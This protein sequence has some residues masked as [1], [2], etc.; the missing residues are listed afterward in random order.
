MAKQGQSLSEPYAV[1]FR[2]Y[3]HSLKDCAA[4]TLPW[5]LDLFIG[6]I[7]AGSILAVPLIAYQKNCTRMR[8][9]IR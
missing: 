2:S 3:A 9:Q 7:R 5:R 8:V 4:H 1:N 6:G